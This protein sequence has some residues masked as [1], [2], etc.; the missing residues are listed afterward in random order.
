MRKDLTGGGISNSSANEANEDLSTSR[1]IL[2]LFFSFFRWTGLGSIIPVTFI[3]AD[4]VLLSG[5]DPLLSD[6]TKS[7]HLLDPFLLLWTPSSHLHCRPFAH[8]VNLLG[9]T[10]YLLTIVALIRWSIGNR[11]D[12][13][14]VVGLCC[15]PRFCT[16]I[17][18]S[19]WLLLAV[20][21]ELL[22]KAACVASSL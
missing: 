9:I 17:D 20:Y 5:G 21:A 10:I 19:M 2:C 4:D 11:F 3:L 1:A 12:K 6:E 8:H 13:R 7:R 14:T 16:T 22:L 15:K 18:R